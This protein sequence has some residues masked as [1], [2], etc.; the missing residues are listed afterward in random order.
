LGISISR[1]KQCVD[2]WHGDED[3]IVPLSH[4]EYIHKHLPNSRLTIVPG[5]AHF[6]LPIHQAE[7]ILQ[8]MSWV[9]SLELKE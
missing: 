6:S 4:S 1:Y 3:N 9:F 5:E 8:E 2:I 7:N